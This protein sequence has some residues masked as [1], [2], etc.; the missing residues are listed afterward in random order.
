M[1]NMKRPLNYCRL[2]Q[3]RSSSDLY[4]ALARGMLRLLYKNLI[5]FTRHADSNIILMQAQSAAIKNG[6]ISGAKRAKREKELV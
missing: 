2:A 4:A 6:C 5:F 1:T 3:T